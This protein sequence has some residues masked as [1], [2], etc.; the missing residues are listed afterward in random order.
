[1]PCASR[2]R[3]PAAIRDHRS[4]DPATTSR[5]RH[6]GAFAMD[7][8][9]DG[10]WALALPGWDDLSTWGY[11]SGTGSFFAQLTRNGN[12]DDNGPDIW[13]TPGASFPAVTAPAHLRPLIASSTGAAAADVTAAM[14]HA[15]DR[16]GAPARYRL[17]V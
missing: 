7:D 14:N 10:T 13:I 5:T 4:Q 15:V 2:L 9:I 12:N 17:A 3:V 1:M 6:G 11:D 8:A 16:Q